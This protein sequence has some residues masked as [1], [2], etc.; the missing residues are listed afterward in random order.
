M[1]EM[2][3]PIQKP[4]RIKAMPF[5][6]ADAFSRNKKPRR[7]YRAPKNSQPLFITVEKLT[8]ISR[9]KRRN[10]TKEAAINETTAS[11]LHRQTTAHTLTQ[12]KKKRHK[13]LHNLATVHNARQPAL[14]RSLCLNHPPP[15]YPPYPRPPSRECNALIWVAGTHT[16]QTNRK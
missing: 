7:A 2:A 3:R 13:P 9:I 12:T 6:P 5:V 10:P 15:P 8:K 4:H 16:A 11:A 14:A 1:A